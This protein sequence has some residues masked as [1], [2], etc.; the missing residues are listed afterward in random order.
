[1]SR[2]K[3]KRPRLEDIILEILKVAPNREATLSQLFREIRTN[4]GL[5]VTY[6]AVS[7]AAKL[8]AERGK[9]VRRRRG[10]YVVYKLPYLPLD[11]FTKI[12]TWSIRDEFDRDRTLAK[13]EIIYGYVDR[14]ADVWSK[15]IE[16]SGGKL[17]RYFRLTAQALLNENPHE[18]FYRLAKWLVDNHKKAVH[19]YEEAKKKRDINLSEKIKRHIRALEHLAK[20]V[21]NRGLGIPADKRRGGPFLLK[22]NFHKG[23]DESAVDLEAVKK[24]LMRSVVGERFLEIRKVQKPKYPCLHISTDASR[25]ILRPPIEEIG[26]T[27]IPTWIPPAAYVQTVS[28]CID[29]FEDW[30]DYDI[31]PR[32]VS[33]DPRSIPYDY[34]VEPTEILEESDPLLRQR[35]VQTAQEGALYDR[36]EEALRLGWTGYRYRKESPK[37]AYIVFRDGRLFPLEHFWGDY[38]RRSPHGYR[39]RNAANRFREIANTYAKEAKYWGVVKCPSVEIIAPVVIWYM[40]YGHPNGQIWNELDDDEFLSIMR[41]PLPDQVVVLELF[42]GLRDRVAPDEVILTFRVVRPFYSMC[43]DWIALNWFKNIE[44]LKDHLIE[45]ERTK[46][47]LKSKDEL[48]EET[49]SY[50]EAFSEMC[51]RTA[52]MHLYVGVPR[53]VVYET[54]KV[55]LPRYEVLID[56]GII[57]DAWNDIDRIGDENLIKL[58]QFSERAV[59]RLLTALSDER[60]AMDL[61]PEEELSEVE[62]GA[63]DI[64]TPKVSLLAHYYAKDVAKDLGQAVLVT[65]FK[66]LL[67]RWGW[68]RS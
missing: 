40:K 15:Y 61:Y 45:V 20:R 14:V 52:V 9:V 54:V 32:P 66:K 29:I 19:A 24:F 2:R 10:A 49:K 7:K 41:N 44:E 59:T 34:F 67:E 48:D 38:V 35:L 31:Y 63:G 39:V 28:A 36:D 47:G 30:E 58:E 11:T 68:P 55:R 33:S 8:L 57:D 3:R 51:M 13:K 46:W 23:E 6:Q 4:Y 5:K 50:V 17:R 1:M 60:K 43:E 56:P 53:H 62:R 16:F 18:L 42:R 25:Y 65:I 27:L 22:Y 37:S 21:F 26:E 64:L 12:E